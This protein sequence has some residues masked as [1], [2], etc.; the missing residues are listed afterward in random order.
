MRIADEGLKLKR[1]RA[2]PHGR[3]SRIMRRS[4]HITVY[5]S[6]DP[7]DIP[8]GVRRARPQVEVTAEE[9]SIGA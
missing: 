8:Q 9:A 7:A 6:D 2:R 5:V 3:A 1:F 4:T